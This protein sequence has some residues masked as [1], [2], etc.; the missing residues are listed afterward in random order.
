MNDRKFDDTIEIKVRASIFIN[1]DGQYI[2]VITELNNH[3][4]NRVVDLQDDIIREALIHLGWRP[5]F[6]IP[7]HI[8]DEVT[9][10]RGTSPN[11]LHYEF[12]GTL[13]EH[14][15]YIDDLW[16]KHWKFVKDN[17]A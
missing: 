12:T 13:A 10:H 8:K 16:Q 5:P 14:N 3:V 4:L 9:D 11:G 6:D 2:E 17:P 15:A 1:D 7:D